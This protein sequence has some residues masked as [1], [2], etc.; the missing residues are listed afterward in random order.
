MA[1]DT[2]LHLAKTICFGQR[3][4]LN[5]FVSAP[6][7]AELPRISITTHMV[8]SWGL[9]LLEPQSTFL[10]FTWAVEFPWKMVADSKSHRGCQPLEA[11]SPN[12]ESHEPFSLK[13]C[14]THI[15]E[16]GDINSRSHQEE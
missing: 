1:E 3:G 5:K 12:L 10:S 9:A 7:D 15:Q 6:L 13:F 8:V 4:F 2:I 16:K 14:Y 11:C